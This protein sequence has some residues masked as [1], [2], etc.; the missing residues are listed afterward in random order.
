MA[1][2]FEQFMKPCQMIDRKTQ[3]DGLGGFT[4]E[5]VDG[6]LF[7]AAVVKDRE[8]AARVAE[9][10]GVTAVYTVTTMTGAQLKFHD[11]FRSL[12]DGLIFRVTTDSKDG[13][14]PEMASF[15]F[16]QVNA[17][18]WELPRD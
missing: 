9:K 10:D 13:E 8:L 7:D 14:T 5:W 16:E 12:S 6:A 1:H 17:E 15:A 2:L 3:S 18:R 4:T 11:V